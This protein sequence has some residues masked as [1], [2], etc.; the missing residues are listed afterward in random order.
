MLRFTGKAVSHCCQ[1]QVARAGAALESS[2]LSCKLW[3]LFSPT[4]LL[5]LQGG[6]FS[7][8]PG[9]GHTVFT[10]TPFTHPGWEGDKFAQSE[11]ASGTWPGVLTAEA[12]AVFYSALQTFQSY[13][14]PPLRRC[15]NFV[16]Q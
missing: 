11:A 5:W 9:G 14:Q 3:V 4:S 8:T 2:L 1:P 6:L 12:E 16:I 15:P 7:H 10:T 13:G